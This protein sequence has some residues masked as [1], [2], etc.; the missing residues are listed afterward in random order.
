MGVRV[1]KHHLPHVIETM[2]SDVSA[3]RITGWN[4]QHHGVADDVKALE[5]MEHRDG[6]GARAWT[7]SV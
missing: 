3:L 6:E 7:R 2:V 1:A 4:R 5:L